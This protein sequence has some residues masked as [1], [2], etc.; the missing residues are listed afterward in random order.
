LIGSTDDVL[1][2]IAFAGSDEHNRTVL[3]NRVR[4]SIT[5]YGMVAPGETVLVAVSGGVDS[6]VL[7][8]LF[9]RLGKELSI[10]LAVGHLDHALRPDSAADAAFV[11]RLARDHDVPF[12][13]RRRD[14]RQRAEAQGEN[15]EAAARACRYAFLDEAAED[16]GATRIA[17]GHTLDDRAETVLFHLARGAGLDGL[18]APAPVRGRIIR[19]LIDLPRAEVAAFAREE[20]L[21][22]REDPTNR[23]TALSRNRIRH[24][25]LPELSRINPRALE[26]IGRASELARESSDLTSALL[27][28]I[29]SSVRLADEAQAGSVSLDREALVSLP[30]PVQRALLRRAL[31]R[32][33]GDL[34]G[35]EAVHLHAVQRLTAPYRGPREAQL[36]RATV[37]SSRERIRVSVAEP[38]PR[39]GTEG[40][41]PASHP[42]DLGETELRALGLR[43]NLAVE[44]ARAGMRPPADRAHE[45][46][47]A[48][49][50]TFPLFLRGRRHGDR[51]HPLGMPADKKLNAFMIDTAIPLAQRDRWPLLCDQRGIIWV[52]G[53][54]LAEGVRITPSTRRILRMHAERLP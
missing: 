42:V 19:P 29:W 33:R 22:W 2:S 43:L 38:E 39:P 25:V 26:A 12:F 54:R 6:V 44:P 18:G 27:D 36:P 11:E 21:T 35:L 20:G 28:P 51:F 10:D 53:V 13:G 37:R 34:T 47:D 17:V 1:P 24:R 40:Q 32:V 15:L 9:R 3:L 8:E 31:K 48:D 45:W 49:R 5:R 30:E 23:D 50:V 7:L 14:V 46:A 4:D 52:T 16:A 41:A